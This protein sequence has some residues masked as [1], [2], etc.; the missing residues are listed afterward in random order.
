MIGI[1]VR[2]REAGELWQE[3]YFDWTLRTVREYHE[4]VETSI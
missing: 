3:R 2:R 4:K 1:N